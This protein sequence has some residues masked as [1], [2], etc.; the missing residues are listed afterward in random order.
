MAMDDSTQDNWYHFECRKC[1]QMHE[2]TTRK[3]SN[4]IKHI[5]KNKQQHQQPDDAQNSW[6]S[7]R[8]SEKNNECA[9]KM[10]W[11]CQ[12]QFQFQ[13]TSMHKTN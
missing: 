8:E 12:F 10:E 13:F 6:L 4:K 3:Y 7:E 2:N 11:K 9:L 5:S 1:K